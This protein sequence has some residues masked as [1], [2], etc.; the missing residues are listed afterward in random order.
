MVTISGIIVPQH[1]NLPSYSAGISIN[2]FAKPVTFQKSLSS[3]NRAHRSY[4]VKAMA[5]SEYIP[6]SLTNVKTYK[7]PINYQ[8]EFNKF[9]DPPYLAVDVY[10]LKMIENK[11]YLY[12]TINE[13]NKFE[14]PHFNWLNHKM[15]MPQANSKIIQSYQHPWET[16]EMFGYSK[17]K[18]LLKLFY[19]L[20]DVLGSFE[21]EFEIFLPLDLNSETFLKFGEY[22]F[23]DPIALY[24]LRSMTFEI[25]AQYGSDGEEDVF[26]SKF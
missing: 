8:S 13:H 16:F 9:K 14:I 10:I 26:S 3:R 6:S 25:D 7:S 22:Q 5:S 1:V 21:N 20:E 23:S 18:S 24:N 11:P 15:L 12:L 17:D 4:T 2:K 19:Y